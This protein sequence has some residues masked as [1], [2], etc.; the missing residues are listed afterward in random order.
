MMKFVSYVNC[1]RTLLAVN[2]CLLIWAYLFFKA[3]GN[4]FFFPAT[5]QWWPTVFSVMG[6][7]Y[8]VVGLM[9]IGKENKAMW[10]ISFLL[11][12]IIA[13]WMKL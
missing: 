5:P 2:A 1:G 10:G 4:S 7:A 12:G 13:A 3:D 8:I 9:T 11:L 6:F